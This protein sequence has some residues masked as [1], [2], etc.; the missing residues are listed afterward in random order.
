VTEDVGTTPRKALTTRRKLA[1]WEREKGLLTF[2]RLNVKCGHE[3]NL[4][5]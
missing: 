3:K 5:N 1:I 4:Y 2:Y